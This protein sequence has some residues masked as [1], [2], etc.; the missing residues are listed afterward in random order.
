MT[1]LI[2]V[3]RDLQT[4]EQAVK[5]LKDSGFGRQDLHL[6]TD[7]PA[8]QRSGSKGFFQS[9]SDLFGSE[10]RETSDR[11][12]D[13]ARQL[14]DWGV[15]GQDA[16]HFAEAIR[17]GGTVITVQAPEDRLDSA[18]QILNTYGPEDMQSQ[19]EQWRA[20]GWQGAGR[21]ADRGTERYAA[22]SFDRRRSGT[23]DLNTEGET[24]LPVTEERLQ[25]GKQEVQRGGV[26]IYQRTSERPVEETLH[27]RDETVNVE[28]HPVDRPARP[29]DLNAFQEGTFEVTETDEEPIVHKEA[30]V[31]EEVTVSKDVAQREHTVRDTVR[32]TDVETEDLAGSEHYDDLESDTE[33][34]AGRERF[35]DIDG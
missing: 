15:P 19:S 20:Q 12:A 11:P 23:T 25:V 22:D 35:D 13:L 31:V 21:A 10:P 32:R 5:D 33:D 18:G 27:L 28:R 2:A 14:A 7:D 17:R 30:R 16:Q 4:A 1:T 3:Y 24:T 8:A 34:M 29:E 26:R 6:L 9:L